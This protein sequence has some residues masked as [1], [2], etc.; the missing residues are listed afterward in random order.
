LPEGKGDMKI[1]GFSDNLKKAIAA[2]GLKLTVISAATGIPTSTL[3]EWTAGR[4][5]KVSEA[6]VKL[7][8]YLG[9]SLDELILTN[10]NSG[11]G[12]GE[13]TVVVVELGGQKF[14]LNF[15]RLK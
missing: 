10:G 4:E 9:V 15:E 11:N 2:R 14:R 7:C 3:S 12:K 1:M 6:L 5:P 13:C 8:K